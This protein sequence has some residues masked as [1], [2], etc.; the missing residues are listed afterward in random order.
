[1]HAVAPS[2]CRFSV[3][4]RL[5]VFAVVVAGGR[6]RTNQAAFN[7][8]SVGLPPVLGSIRG[9]TLSTAALSWCTGRYLAASM[10]PLDRLCLVPGIARLADHR[11]ACLGP[12]RRLSVWLRVGFAQIS[13][14]TLWAD[15]WDPPGN[16]DC[17]ASP[18]WC[19]LVDRSLRESSLGSSYWTSRSWY[20]MCFVTIGNHRC[21]V[22][23]LA[24]LGFCCGTAA[25]WPFTASA[26]RT[27]PISSAL[28]HM[29]IWLTVTGPLLL[30]VRSLDFGA[31]TNLCTRPRY[32]RVVKWQRVQLDCR[33]GPYW[34]R[35]WISRLII[36]C[37]RSISDCAGAD[38][39]RPPT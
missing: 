20:L 26:R 34:R 22:R 2:A 19:Q 9:M 3:T 27:R 10:A 5:L 15:S 29:L 6:G 7:I 17:R 11:V 4:G 23:R 28:K 31:S 25:D 12:P 37:E 30:F 8:G 16:G 14:L 32:S 35:A 38:L 1:M 36:T 33:S 39:L 13:L 18:P 21:L 24:L